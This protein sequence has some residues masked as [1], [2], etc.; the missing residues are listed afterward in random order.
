M[1]PIAP[2]PMDPTAPFDSFTLGPHIDDMMPIDDTAAHMAATPHIGGTG[3][4][5]MGMGGAAGHI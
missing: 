2:P 1:A 3:M 4:G 5:G